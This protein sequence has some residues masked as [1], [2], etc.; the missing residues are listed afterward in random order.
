M[1]ELALNPHCQEK[2]FD[3]ITA[4][5]AKYGGKLTAEGLQEMDYL[6]GVLLEALR[7][8]PALITM[9]K[10][11]TKPY[12]LPKTSDQSEAVTIQPGT[13]VAIPVLAIHR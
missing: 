8:H 6:E 10:M 11:C 7:K 9:M 13:I 2:L 4:N 3:E 1:Y 5:M 12:T